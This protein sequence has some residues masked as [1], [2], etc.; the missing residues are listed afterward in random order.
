MKTT[1]WRFSFAPKRPSPGLIVA[2][3]MLP[4]SMSP[5]K[6]PC[7]AAVPADMVFSVCVLFG[8]CV[9]CVCVSKKRRRDGM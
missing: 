4:P 9:V 3:H 1:L 5:K 7:R 2:I 6:P 8:V